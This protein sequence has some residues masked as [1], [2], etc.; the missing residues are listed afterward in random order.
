MK[1]TLLSLLLTILYYVPARAQVV[2]ACLGC[3]YSDVATL[4]GRDKDVEGPYVHKGVGSY[5]GVVEYS[6][7]YSDWL[8]RSQVRRQYTF[9]N[10][11]CVTYDLS[12]DGESDKYT[13][14][15]R[16]TFERLLREEGYAFV[17]KPNYVYHPRQKLY[18]HVKKKQWAYVWTN[19]NI[20]SVTMSSS[21]EPIQMTKLLQ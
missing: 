17:P 10:G 6:Y 9:K 14:H 13:D 21:R 15:M 18:F 19:G 7:W 11:K 20:V 1:L 16:I 4:Y 12:V 5:E 3:D 2:D 8:S